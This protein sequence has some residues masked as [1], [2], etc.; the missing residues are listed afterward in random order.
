MF[1]FIDELAEIQRVICF[2]GSHITY[3]T[4]NPL[5]RSSLLSVLAYL[6]LLFL[7]REVID[8]VIQ[9]K[10]SSSGSGFFS[11]DTFEDI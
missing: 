10:N 11:T 2:P 6:L 9:V 3:V 1:C 4:L 5:S 7:S 8:G